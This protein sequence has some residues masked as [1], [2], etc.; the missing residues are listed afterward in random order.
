MTWSSFG[1]KCCTGTGGA[2]EDGVTGLMREHNRKEAALLYF[3]LK[4]Q[5]KVLLALVT[6]E[7]NDCPARKYIKVRFLW[8]TRQMIG[9]SFS[10]AP[11]IPCTDSHIL[12]IT[13]QYFPVAPG[14]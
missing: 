9:S 14:L 1:L 3:C 12:T 4:S 8:L 10:H 5:N 13:T 11:R 7:G 6:R 2:G